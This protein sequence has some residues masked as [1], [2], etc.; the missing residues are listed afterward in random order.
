MRMDSRLGTTAADLVNRLK[1][2]ELADLFY[3]NSQESASRRI[4]RRICEVRREGRITS[5]HQLV[6]VIREVAGAGSGRI[7]PATRVFQALRIAVN[8]EIENLANL[9][10]IAPD[11]L[12]A[13]GRFGVIAFHSV[14]DKPVKED[15]RKRK[16][17]GLYEV[18]TKKPVTADDEERWA[19]PRARSAKLRVARR[20]K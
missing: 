20:C 7:H 10:R 19:N 6:N 18:L 11:L 5:T 3:Y 12:A 17:E 14:E 16:A 8:R 4:A 13:G 15:F 1:E 9:L 2:R